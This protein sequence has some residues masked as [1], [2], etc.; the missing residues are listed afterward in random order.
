MRILR[1]IIKAFL[2]FAVLIVGGFFILRSLMLFWGEST[3]KNSLKQI[4]LAE[5]KGTYGSQCAALGSVGA[6]G[7]KSVS[8]QLRFISSSEFLTEV[9]CDGF[10]YDPILISQGTLP[11]FVTKVPGTSGFTINLEE[12]G[13]EL[14]AFSLEIDRLSKSSGFDFYFLNKTKAL[15][16]QNGNLIKNA[17][18]NP[19]T[20]GPVTMCSG[21]GYQCCNEVSHLG[22]GDKILGLNDCEQSCYSQCATRPVL[23]SFNTF[24]LLD[25]KTRTIT[26]TSGSPVE[27]T[28]VADSGN[29][30]SMSGVL[31]FG[32]GKKAQLSGLAGQ[33]SHTYLC[34]RARCEYNVVVILEDNWGVKSANIQTNKLKIIVT[35]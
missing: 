24:P 34:T 1:L 8:Y 6:G 18:V 27:F 35:R 30:T 33:M 31:D 12:S 5:K 13:I 25:L 28:Y 20:Q 7:E 22:T 10:E 29:A 23:L 2:F 17:V 19:N 14:E 3:I 9:V 11:Q 15:I 21:Y 26:V 16:A 4:V 32:D